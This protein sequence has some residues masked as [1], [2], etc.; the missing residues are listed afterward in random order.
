MGMLAADSL[1]LEAWRGGAREGRFEFMVRLRSGP[2]TGSP[3]NPRDLLGALCWY[4]AAVRGKV[5]LVT[6]ATT[7]IRQATA[8]GSQPS[9]R[10]G[11]PGTRDRPGG[12]LRRIAE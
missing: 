10:R 5:A 2:A 3:W 12:T 11:R 4:W 7:G 6:G 8:V 1:Q 9:A